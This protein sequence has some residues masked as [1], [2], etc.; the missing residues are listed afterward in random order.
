MAAT[1][2]HGAAAVLL[3]ALGRDFQRAQ[4]QPGAGQAPSVPGEHG[5][6]I[7]QRE[8][9]AFERHLARLDML[10]IG[11]QELQPMGVVA[12]QVGFDQDIGDVV[13]FVPWHPRRDEQRFGELDECGRAVAR[14]GRGGRSGI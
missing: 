5:A 6:V 13:G 11:S 2:G 4:H 14:R 3:R 8:R 7:G 9:P 1:Y 12:E 10:Q